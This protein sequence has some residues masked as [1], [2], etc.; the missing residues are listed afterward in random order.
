VGGSPQVNNQ[1]REWHAEREPQ[2]TTVITGN[3]GSNRHMVAI[4]DALGYQA[5]G[6]WTFWTLAAASVN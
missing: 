2:L 3:A 1:V 4:N 5:F 6:Q